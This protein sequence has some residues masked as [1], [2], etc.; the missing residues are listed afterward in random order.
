M[1]YLHL[2]VPMQEYERK[3]MTKTL[4]KKTG[5]RKGIVIKKTSPATKE[6][7]VATSPSRK[8]STTTRAKHTIA[9]TPARKTL[10]KVQKA[11]PEEKEYT[12]YTNADK[13]KKVAGLTFQRISEL[14]NIQIDSDQF[15]VVVEI[16]K[17]GTTRQEINHRVRDILPPTSRTGSPKAVSNL[18]SGVVNKMAACGF[19]VQGNWKMITPAS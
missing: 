9:G 3:I 14:T 1:D 15:V 4:V 5:V 17:G 19:A 12:K 11:K 2:E 13:G 16:L 8:V 6:K 10:A 18:V 7:E